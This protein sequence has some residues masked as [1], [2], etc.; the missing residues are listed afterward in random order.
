MRP[1]LI[2]A[3]RHLSTFADTLQQMRKM[4]RFR[5]ILVLKMDKVELT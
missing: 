1:K 3:R 2:F 5:E 4:A